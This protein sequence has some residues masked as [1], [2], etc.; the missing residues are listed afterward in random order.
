MSVL[1]NPEIVQSFS[2][3]S[4]LYKGKNVKVLIPEKY[5]SPS[6]LTPYNSFVTT[7]FCN[8]FVANVV[9]RKDMNTALREA[10]E[11]AEQKIRTEKSK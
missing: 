11:A 7:E 4:P 6:P 2:Q 8:A 3:D 1:N 10:A 9:D 5:A